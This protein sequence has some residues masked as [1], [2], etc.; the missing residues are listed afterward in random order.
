M[1]IAYLLLT[2]RNTQILKRLILSG[3]AFAVADQLGNAGYVL[4]AWILAVGGGGYAF[5]VMRS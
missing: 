2:N 3:I 1:V 4:L 5:L